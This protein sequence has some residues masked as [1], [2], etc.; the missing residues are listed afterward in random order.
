MGTLINYHV[1]CKLVT[2]PKRLLERMNQRMK[3]CLSVGGCHRVS[4]I[5]VTPPVVIM[6]PKELKQLQKLFIGGLSFEKPM[7]V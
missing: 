1:E 7:R 6:S 5:K 4:I 3:N 2:V